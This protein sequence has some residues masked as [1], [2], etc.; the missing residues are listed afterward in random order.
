MRWSKAYYPKMMMMTHRLKSQSKSS[1]RTPSD[2]SVSAQTAAKRITASLAWT[3]HDKQS[4]PTT[5][6]IV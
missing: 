5:I 6:V 1:V 2:P 4:S 3:T